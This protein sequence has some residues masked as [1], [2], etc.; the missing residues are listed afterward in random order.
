MFYLHGGFSI[1]QSVSPSLTGFTKYI[2]G[3]SGAGAS[4]LP[5]CVSDSFWDWP[6]PGFFWPSCS[7]KL[8]GL[9]EVDAGLHPF[10]F[11]F[12]NGTK[13]VCFYTDTQFFFLNSDTRGRACSAC[14]RVWP[15]TFGRLWTMSSVQEPNPLWASSG[16]SRRNIQCFRINGEG[17]RGNI[18]PSSF[19]V[20][21]RRHRLEKR[22]R[23]EFDQRSWL[24]FILKQPC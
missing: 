1:K 12:W 9:T 14:P 15:W 3:P 2:I 8:A 22:Q 19:T 11:F 20:R 24:C 23:N 18:L 13:S 21:K 5:A 16:S 10:F 17:L 7:W 4:W 6:F